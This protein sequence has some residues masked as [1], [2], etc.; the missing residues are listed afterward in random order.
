[1]R[2]SSDAILSLILERPEDVFHQLEA[3]GF[4]FD[5]H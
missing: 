2:E 3:Q 5:D 4:P 1:M